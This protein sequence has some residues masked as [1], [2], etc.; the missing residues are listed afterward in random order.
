MKTTLLLVTSLL[1]FVDTALAKVPAVEVTNLSIACTVVTPEVCQGE[2]LEINWEV[3][4]G[5]F[6]ASNAF[7][8]QLSDQNGTFNNPIILGSFSASAGAGMLSA[9]TPIGIPDGSNY[10][11]RII[12]STPSMVGPSNETPILIR[13]YEP[14]SHVSPVIVCGSLEAFD[15]QGGFPANGN[16]AGIYV[17]NGTFYPS[18]SGPGF[19]TV[20][21]EVESN[22]GC[23]STYELAI[24]VL[25]SPQV[26][27]IPLGNMCKNAMPYPLQATPSGGTW[28]GAGV[29]EGMF[30]PNEVE[31]STATLTYTFEDAN[32][33]ADSQQI[34][35]GILPLPVVSF[36]TTG[37]I[38]ENS[39]PL[40]LMN[41]LPEGGNY[42]G[43]FVEDDMFVPSL[44]F[45]G[46]HEVHYAV[47]SPQG[48][49]ALE[50]A[51]ILVL[52][53]D[54]PGFDLPET[55]CMNAGVYNLDPFPSGGAFVGITTT[56][57]TFDPADLPEGTHTI[58]YELENESGCNVATTKSIEIL[59]IPDVS[60]E[61]PSTICS[62]GPVLELSGGYPEGG[63]YTVDET[64][65]TSIDPSSL[66]VGYHNA[67]Y[68]YENEN[69]CMGMELSGFMVLE[70]PN[71]PNLLFDGISLT[72]QT[73]DDSSILWYFN[74]TLIDEEGSGFIPSEN[75]VYGATTFNGECTSP[76]AEIDISV[77]GVEEMM[78]AGM[79]VYPVPFVEQLI[80]DAKSNWGMNVSLKL[81]DSNARLAAEW[82]NDEI[83]KL[84]GKY[85]VNSRLDQLSSGTYILILTNENSSL[86]TL[87]TK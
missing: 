51:E 40:L 48:C 14:V 17:D 75:G 31:G 7:Q 3:Q 13:P 80:I 35:V 19:H 10:H 81:Y 82:A 79:N 21:Y 5:S 77:T 64:I 20:T 65:F 73:D 53:A 16:Y 87:V 1:L 72:A 18:V 61:L 63:T 59:P 39:E 15:L 26:E 54:A 42:F 71:A 58:S 8:V 46:Y 29:I 55:L 9:M 67:A 25:P 56:N 44:A 11:V 68:Y 4:N 62:T 28:E 49:T 50:T 30:D 69:G 66:T 78:E 76:L 45:P 83:Q 22:V 12:S 52:A 34:E 86:R 60:L 74:G 24:E 2:Q 43:S 33:C 38:C 32:G 47:T 6:E 23:M 41:G 36:Q 37:S 57:N 84:N 70:A 85:I 27:V